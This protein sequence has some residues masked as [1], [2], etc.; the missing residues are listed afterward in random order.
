M[1][2][3][4]IAARA[5]NAATTPMIIA[6]VFAPESESEKQDEQEETIENET[7]T[8][9]TDEKEEISEWKKECK[10]NCHL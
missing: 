8:E 10:G 2:T 5:I 7:S 1:I 3:A 4:I 9:D 6:A